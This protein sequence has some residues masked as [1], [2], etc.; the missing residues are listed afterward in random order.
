MKP[1][2]QGIF[3]T[4]T[5]TEVG[6]TFVSAVLLKLLLDHGVKAT[7]FKPVATG[8]EKRG[9]E[10][11]PEDLERVKELTGLQ[12]SVDLHCPYRY[13]YPVAPLAAAQLE[14]RPINVEKIYKSLDT[15]LKSYPVV[16]V[17]GVGG[18]LVPITEKTLLL[19]IMEDLRLPSLVVCR[20]SLGTVN[21][22][23]LTIKAI[24]DRDIQVLG[25]VTSGHRDDSDQAVTT[26]PALIEKFSGVPFLGHVPFYGQQNGDF[27]SFVNNKASFLKKVLFVK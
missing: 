3:V 25:F 6:K 27:S 16:V 23:L 18:V 26:S 8:C 17:E 13:I 7:Y 2:H 1:C 15:L 20:P 10:L 12:F 11:I 19:D 14:D 9:H 4:A 5:D 22:S 24:Q 21:H